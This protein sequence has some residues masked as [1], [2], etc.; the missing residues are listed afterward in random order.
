MHWG[1]KPLPQNDSL[2]PAKW[3][4][5]KKEGGGGHFKM[6]IREKREGEQKGKFS[7][8]VGTGWWTM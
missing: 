8:K 5:E 2:H 3:N 6:I 7:N 1:R 4:I